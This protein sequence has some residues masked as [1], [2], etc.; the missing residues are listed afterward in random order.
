MTILVDERSGFRQLLASYCDLVQV[1]SDSRQIGSI[2]GF[3][4]IA[5]QSNAHSLMSST[6]WSLSRPKMKLPQAHLVRIAYKSRKSSFI[7]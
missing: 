6:S 1:E 7:F 5:R 2:Q 3:N 4:P